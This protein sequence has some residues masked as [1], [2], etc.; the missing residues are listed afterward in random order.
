MFNY[1]NV[2]AV[3]YSLTRDLKFYISVSVFTINGSDMS[4]LTLAL[5]AASDNM[6]LIEAVADG[7][8]SRETVTYL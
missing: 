4:M 5:L 6:C 1:A 3:I 2:T 7:L 8:W